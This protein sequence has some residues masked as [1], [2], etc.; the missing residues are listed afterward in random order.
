MQSRSN[1][2]GVYG[3]TATSFRYG[4][5]QD[6]HC[7]HSNIL[8]TCK[9]TKSL[10]AE[11]AVTF[12]QNILDIKT[13]LP[14]SVDSSY[15]RQACVMHRTILLHSLWLIY[16]YEIHSFVKFSQS[17]TASP[18]I[19]GS[20]RV[21]DIAKMYASSPTPPYKVRFKRY[22][23][24]FLVIESNVLHNLDNIGDREVLTMEEK[25][26]LQAQELKEAKVRATCALDKVLTSDQM[27]TLREVAGSES[28]MSSTV[29]TIKP[30]LDKK[31][32]SLLHQNIRF[33]F[34]D[35]LDSRTE[36]D[37]DI[38]HQEETETKVM[39]FKRGLKSTTMDS[40]PSCSTSTSGDKRGHSKGKKK[41]V[42]RWDRTLPEYS[43]FSLRKHK[44]TTD[45]ALEQLAKKWGLLSSRF[46]VNGSKDRFAIT[47]QRV[48]VWRMTREDIDKR[49][50][51]GFV[52]DRIDIT[53]VASSNRPMALGSLEGNL[54][55]LRLRV[56]DRDDSSDNHHTQSPEQ[57]VVE[58]PSFR[59]YFTN[60]LD[61][62]S[63]SSDN[64]GHCISYLNLFGPQ[65]FGSPLPLNTDIGIAILQSDYR[66][67]LLLLLFCPN[68]RFECTM[69]GLD[70][71]LLQSWFEDASRYGYNKDDS[72]KYF[73]VLSE[74]WDSYIDALQQKCGLN[75]MDGGRSNDESKMFERVL[76]IRRLLTLDESFITSTVFRDMSYPF[77]QRKLLD[78]IAKKWTSLQKS[79]AKDL[80]MSM[81]SMDC[82]KVWEKSLPKN[83]KQLFLNAYQS[84]FFNTLAR[85]RQ[86]LEGEGGNDDNGSSGSGLNGYAREG[87]IVLVNKFKQP[88]SAWDCSE[89]NICLVANAVPS[90]RDKFEKRQATDGDDTNDTS[91]DGEEDEDVLNDDTAVG[92]P[93]RRSYYYV[94]AASDVLE[95]VYKLT[96]V[97]LPLPGYATYW[98]SEETTNTACSVSSTL[99]RDKCNVLKTGDHSD[100]AYRVPGAYRHMITMAKNVKVFDTA[101]SVPLLEP[102][103]D[104]KSKSSE[105]QGDAFASRVEHL[106]ENKRLLSLIQSMK[107]ANP[108][109]M[110][111]NSHH[112]HNGNSN[113]YSG[114]NSG[115][116]DEKSEGVVGTGDGR[117]IRQ[118][119]S[120]DYI[121]L[122]FSLCA[123][124]YATTFIDNVL[125]DEE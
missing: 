71:T 124:S 33:D 5:V 40:S 21:V 87:D 62:V 85:E 22:P 95:K 41:V 57:G 53:D 50:A 23:S 38:T 19:G 115:G 69:G 100:K 93:S 64:E 122:L 72:K 59:E 92:I 7:T 13:Y 56:D 35:A 75:A 32:R 101:S 52:N 39:V 83:L 58:K 12:E 102:D 117:M 24:D 81:A 3:R 67:A 10:N 109:I 49:E 123:S 36:I 20:S 46:S 94:V 31:R 17:P 15:Q 114:G 6:S 108:N 70:S 68:T 66:K 34:D 76:M 47:T 118:E 8:R 55:C 18:F 77:A 111:T 113:G 99:S 105:R 63:Q 119:Q 9:V 61:A 112:S 65:R 11:Q 82:K 30:P 26:A 74:K 120:E 42:Q 2:V 89:R 43:H 110:N 96:H 37:N 28:T 91:G 121:D 51:E 88:L 125:C 84:S 44:L 14:G 16:L 29:L 104:D 103:D 27:V 54:F 4:Q 107:A 48:S 97:V 73:G 80:Q 98:P 79:D 106:W 45:E 60:K 86:I 116:D 25:L 1:K 78:A 90:Y